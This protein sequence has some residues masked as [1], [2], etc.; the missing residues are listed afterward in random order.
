MQRLAAAARQRAARDAAL[1]CWRGDGGWGVAAA[2]GGGAGAGAGAGGLPE[3]A[4]RAGVRMARRMAGKGGAKDGGAGKG[5]CDK[6]APAQPVEKRPKPARERAPPPDG[7]A[8]AAKGETASTISAAGGSSSAAAAGEGDRALLSRTVL[9]LPT[10]RPLMPGFERTLEVTD[11]RL[12]TPLYRMAKKA[13]EEGRDDV[14]VGLFAEHPRHWDALESWAHS[15]NASVGA[16]GG[17]GGSVLARHV[18]SGMADVKA[19]YHLGADGASAVD[20]GS[21]SEL[22]TAAAFSRLRD[23]PSPGGF[24]PVGTVAKVINLTREGDGAELRVTLRGLRRV[25]I[26]RDIVDTPEDKARLHLAARKHAQSI[27]FK[28]ANLMDKRRS[29]GGAAAMLLTDLRSKLDMDE[30]TE[31]GGDA[32]GAAPD[33]DFVKDAEAI[34]AGE[35]DDAQNN[36]QQHAGG[37]D[38]HGDGYNSESDGEEG[39]EPFN[40]VMQEVLDF[41]HGA[42]IMPFPGG[43]AVYPGPKAQQGGGFPGLP[44]PPGGPG[45]KAAAGQPSPPRAGQAIKLAAAALTVGPTSVEPSFHP[46]RVEVVE[47]SCADDCNPDDEYTKT[48]MREAVRKLEELQNISDRHARVMNEGAEGIDASKV[49]SH[50]GLLADLAAHVCAETDRRVTANALHEVSVRSRLAGVI[51]AL[52]TEIAYAKKRAADEPGHPPDGQL[53]RG[54]SPSDFFRELSKVS[55]GNM[56]MRGGRGGQGGK[57]QGGQEETP[58]DKYRKRFEGFREAVKGTPVEERIEEELARLEQLDPQGSEYSVV[59]TYLDWL[60]KVPWGTLPDD[61]LDI[62]HAHEV[63]EEDHYGLKDVKDRILELIAVGRLRG[64]V[65]GKIILLVGPP[66]VGKTSIGRSIARAVGRPYARVAIGGLD[67]THELKGHRRTYVGAMPGKMVH[68]LAH[69]KAMNPLILLDEVDKIGAGSFRGNPSATL[70]EILDPSQNSEFA[71]T[72]MDVPIDLSKVLFVATANTTD[73][74]PKPLLDRMEVIEVGAYLKE[75]KIEIAKAYLEPRA[76]ESSGLSES[77]VRIEA[78]ALDG[79]VEDYCRDAGVRS[80]EKAIEKIY[81]KVALKRVRDTAEAVPGLP[82]EQQQH[83]Q[84]DGAGAV[85][86]VQERTPV[87]GKAVAEGGGAHEAAVQLPPVVVRRADLGEYLGVPVFRSDKMYE[88]LP[89]GVANGLAYTSFGGEVLLIETASSDAVGGDGKGSMNITGQLGDVMKESSAIA[90]RLARQA[91]SVLCDMGDQRVGEAEVG[92]WRPSASFFADSD[93]HLHFPAGAV[94]KDGP[95]AGI[96]ITTALLSSAL[97]L[98][99]ASDVAMTGEVSLTGRVLPVGG[100]REKIVAAKRSGMTTVILPKANE[101]DVS[102]LPEQV[103]AGIKIFYA[104]WYPEVLPVVF[105]GFEDMQHMAERGA[106]AFVKPSVPRRARRGPPAQQA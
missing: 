46:A 15:L 31:D 50:P 34:G 75:E 68:S 19:A 43:I 10:V 82:A 64:S 73:T 58:A 47:Y 66:G 86:G 101:R 97:R 95:S 11:P 36:E 17:A 83:A 90:K 88:R 57:E 67:D 2:A 9:A 45:G 74:I 22:A 85:E 61:N 14:E 25:Q 49:L 37:D 8:N 53:T 41:M 30:S 12:A 21:A 91:L 52:E 42:A 16:G 102:E 81:R 63:L 62:V 106:G 44:F 38:S 3:V 32:L 93:V 56:R 40:G 4:M 27:E 1:R 28:S 39:E 54:R 35:G 76:R 60:T 72:Y 13:Q 78:D 20:G 18:T 29:R 87:V 48:L 96:A 84:Q 98:Q 71:D 6:G 69:A 59:R 105:P 80:L 79:L 33:L 89:V 5:G 7:G 23:G 100:I 94:P 24:L 51:Q 55:M 65:Q 103:T 26:A 99:C 77:D 70:M 104:S 92:E